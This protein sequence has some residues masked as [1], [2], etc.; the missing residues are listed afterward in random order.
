[1]KAYYSNLMDALR[2]CSYFPESMRKNLKLSLLSL[3]SCYHLPYQNRKKDQLLQKNFL[4]LYTTES[5]LLGK[6]YFFLVISLKLVGSNRY[7]R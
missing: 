1:M 2:F 6:C 7:I 3:K 4:M 5:I